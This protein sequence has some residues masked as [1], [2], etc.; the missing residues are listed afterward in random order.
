MFNIYY[1]YLTYYAEA[2]DT[3]WNSTGFL[4]WLYNES[5]VKDTVVRIFF[6]KKLNNE[7]TMGY[8]FSRLLMIDGVMEYH[9]IM[10]VFI[11]VPIVTIQDILL[12]ING[13]IVLLYVICFPN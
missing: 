10:E 11:H 13:K 4:A 9:V 3:Y 6:F 5:P 2:P 12:H 8:L 1:V 7:K